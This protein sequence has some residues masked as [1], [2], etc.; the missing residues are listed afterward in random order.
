MFLFKTSF[1]KLIVSLI[2]PVLVFSFGFSS[3]S[4]AMTIQQERE[5]GEKI[6]QQAKS[7]WPLVQAPSINNYVNRVGKRILQSIEPQPFD[8]EFFV[9]NTPE[10]NAFA[11]P[12]GKVF[13]DSGIMLLMENEDELSAII[14]H[15]ISHVVARH[16]AK[17]S[18]KGQ[19]FQLA[20][21]GAILAGILL[22]GQAAGAIATTSMAASETAFLK[23][24]REDEEEADYLGLRFMERA[25]YDRRA[26]TTMFKK[27]RRIEGPAGSTPPAYLL[28]HPALEERMANLEIQ[29]LLSPKEK[30]IP[31]PVGNFQR[32]QTKL[33]VEEKDIARSV[34]YF[35]NWS[36]RNPNDSE[37]F[38]GLG[39]TQKRMGGLDRAIESFS[40]AIALNA[41]DSEFFRELGI[42]YF[43]KGNLSAAQTNLG[44]A[45]S[46]SPSDPLTFFYLGRVGIE[47]KKP[48]EAL[49]DLLRA[50]ELDPNLPEIYY[51]LGLAY[52]AK[53]LLGPAY[54]NMGYHYKSIGDMK[55]ALAHFNRALPYF[56][57]N[58]SERQVIQKEI[59]D[60]TPKKKAPG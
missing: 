13:I 22:G 38:F 21:L 26:M 45:R 48:D 15:E 56:P 23:Y 52:G 29:M 2:F 41:Q 7:R 51:H 53:G 44:K 32:I 43:L 27:M 28:T 58:S 47:N 4:S 17:R 14:C 20:T 54:Q 5:M 50:K 31:N 30:S 18:E 1:M 12:G 55:T 9:L 57:E 6:V 37:A 42:A 49:Q 8:Y 35:E 40:K 24:S 34:A 33:V 39:L 36:K 3:L 16:I 46:L 19:I 11:V 59:E 60:L 10:V 25:G